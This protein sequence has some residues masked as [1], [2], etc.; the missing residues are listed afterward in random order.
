ME[1]LRKWAEELAEKGRQQERMQREAREKEEAERR[2]NENAQAHHRIQENIRKARELFLPG[3]E[4]SIRQQF[5]EY[6]LKWEELKSRRELPPLSFNI[7]PWPVLGSAATRPSDITLQRVEEFV[8]HPLKKGMELKSRR[9]RVRMEILKWHPD[10]F[11][12]MV[13][14]K[15]VDVAEVAEG[16]GLVARILTQIM[17]K[18]TEKENRGY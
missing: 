10:K 8:Y 12:V 7:L 6:E 15:V 4:F 1:R 2:A 3:D 9:D 11:N 5:E 13:L 18:E 17:E 14:G 16:A